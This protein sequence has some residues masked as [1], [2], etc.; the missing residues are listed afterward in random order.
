MSSTATDWLWRLAF[1]TFPASINS[2]SADAED[3]GMETPASTCGR[4]RRQRICLNR[5]TPIQR[6]V[7]D[8][9]IRLVS[10]RYSILAVCVAPTIEPQLRFAR[11]SLLKASWTC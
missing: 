9:S 1:P 8:Q 10:L 5:A 6:S 11:L 3:A 7:D 2:R 4:R